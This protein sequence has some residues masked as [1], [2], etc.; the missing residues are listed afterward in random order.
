MPLA[1]ARGRGS[2]PM[3]FTQSQTIQYSRRSRTVREFRGWRPAL[4]GVGPGLRPGWASQRPAPTNVIYLPAA[5]LAHL[6]NV[7]RNGYAACGA[8]IFP[9]SDVLKGTMRPYKS[10][11]LSL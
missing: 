6:A 9:S 10:R 5:A 11:V 7:L 2:K 3:V 4:Q 1:R 8:S